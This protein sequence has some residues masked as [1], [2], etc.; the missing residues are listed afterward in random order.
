MTY[1][2]PYLQ[3]R[4][5]QSS[6]MMQPSMKLHSPSVPNYTD[7]DANFKNLMFYSN[8][9][10]PAD[11]IPPMQLPHLNR[12]GPGTV[13]PTP[14]NHTLRCNMHVPETAS[15]FGIMH[16]IPSPNVDDLKTQSL[17]SFSNSPLTSTPTGSKR[18]RPRADVISTLQY[19]GSNSSCTI[20]CHVCHRVFPREKSLQAHLRTHTGER[21]YRCDYPNCTK[22][23]VQSGQLKTHQRLH[24]GEKPFKCSDDGCLVRFTHANRHCPDHPNAKLVRDDR[25]ALERLLVGA[26]K[27]DSTITEWLDKYVRLR[28]DRT[29]NTQRSHLKRESSETSV[30]SDE[31]SGMSKSDS[32]SST[33]SDQPVTSPL[34]KCPTIMPSRGSSVKRQLLTDENKESF[35]KL[36]EAEDGAVRIPLSPKRLNQVVQVPRIDPRQPVKKRILAYNQLLMKQMKDQPE[37]KVTLP[38]I[39][40]SLPVLPSINS[41]K[42]KLNLGNDSSLSPVQSLL[43]LEQ[44]KSPLQKYSFLKDLESVHEKSTPVKQPNTCSVIVRRDSAEQQSRRSP[45]PNKSE[46]FSD[47]WDG[48][49]ALMQLASSP[50]TKVSANN[51]DE[52]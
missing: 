22:S 2:H 46:T 15:S 23:F 47:R 12:F 52:P 19:F 49:L 20:R 45:A 26:Q 40:R 43:Q 48:A 10:W 50:P 17:S 51:C 14:V 8:W 28:L 3:S 13:L 30:S 5:Q 6:I 25:G 4:D 37:N 7:Y 32:L 18:G 35:I 24:S 36:N 39:E 11:T 21:P 34:I 44:Q 41:P 33:S 27:Q 9:Q 31:E 1:S 38:P 16:G 42:R 29:N